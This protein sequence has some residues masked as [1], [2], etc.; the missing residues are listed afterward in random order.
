MTLHAEEERTVMRF[1]PDGELLSSDTGLTE[2]VASLVRQVGVAARH[3]VLQPPPL[4]R[5]L[6]GV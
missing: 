2:R 4:A 5:S 6:R 3:G 1:A